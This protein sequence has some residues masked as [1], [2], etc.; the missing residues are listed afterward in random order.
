MLTSVPHDPVTDPD[1]LAMLFV[2]QYLNDIAA[3]LQYGAAP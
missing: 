1:A 3:C 2:Q